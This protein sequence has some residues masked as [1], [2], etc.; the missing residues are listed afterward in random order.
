VKNPTPP[1]QSC[2]RGTPFEGQK[3]N[4]C[5]LCWRRRGGVFDL[6]EFNQL[7]GFGVE[8]QGS[9]ADCWQL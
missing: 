1:Q 8:V 4:P 3:P 2:G 9:T 6:C 7:F 5:G